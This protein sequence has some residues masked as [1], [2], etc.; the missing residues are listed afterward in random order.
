MFTAADVQTIYELPLALHEE[1]LD[2]RVAE[3]LNIWS[4]ARP[5]STSGSGSSRR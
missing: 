2:D 4:R 5:T 1:G 3:L